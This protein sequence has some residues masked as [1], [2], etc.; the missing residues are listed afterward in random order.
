M[1]DLISVIIPVYNVE[2]YLKK[3]VDSV[4][5]QDYINIEIIL[6]DD[7]STDSSGNICDEYSNKY[8]NKV[9]VIHKKNGGL[10]D[11]RNYGIKKSSGKYLIFVDSDDW[12]EE[13]TISYSY[14]E[15]IE[16]N[17]Q[18]AVY[19]ISIDQ[20]GK[21]AKI[22]KPSEKRIISSK[23]AII[24]LNSFRGIDVS[25]CNKMF[26]REI[27]NNIEFPVGKLCEDYYIMYKL[28]ENTK[29]IILIPE[30][31]YHYYQR[32]NSIV[33]NSNLNMDYLYAAEEE[34]KYLSKYN[35]D[36]EFA[37]ITGYVFANITLY[38]MKYIKNIKNEKKELLKHMKKHKKSVLNN[39]Y[40]PTVRKIQYIIFT[41]FNNVYDLWL[42]IKFRKVRKNK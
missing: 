14:K 28:F 38:H 36:I 34:M 12:I 23:L 35:K 3:C 25:A 27:F 4:L 19:G 31:F 32:P 37:G 29:Q 22:K 20:E 16:N 7:G 15:I 30:V 39:K 13:N 9:K 40:L 2:K 17:A 21:K 24:Y 8:P 11:A 33:R 41:Y 18:I 42:R 10:S 26:C 6:V 1:N 5:K